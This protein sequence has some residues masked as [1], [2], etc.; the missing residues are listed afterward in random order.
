MGDRHSFQVKY[1]NINNLD[2][3]CGKGSVYITEY[4]FSLE[5][6]I[7]VRQQLHRKIYQRLISALDEINFVWNAHEYQWTKV[8]RIPKGIYKTRNSLLGSDKLYNRDQF[9]LGSWING[10]T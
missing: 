9:T 1:L 10:A 2:I 8:V 6:W 7:S 4:I 3:I 5:K